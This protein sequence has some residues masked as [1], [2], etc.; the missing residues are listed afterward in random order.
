[1]FEELRDAWR[2]AVSN[3]Y[4]ELHGGAEDG[5]RL[6]AMR[7]DHAAALES[8]RRVEQELE[9]TQ[10]ELKQ[11]R[12]E[13]TAY[14][15]RRDMAQR[16]GDEETAAVA[17]RFVARYERRVR[18]LE[19][20]ASALEAE[21]GLRRS[22]V[23]E[24][25]VALTEVEA[26]ARVSGGATAAGSAGPASPG[27]GGAAPAGAAGPAAA[28]A[29]AEPPGGASRAS[30]RSP[31]EPSAGGAESGGG[32]SDAGARPGRLFEE[33]DEATFKQMELREREREAERR[34]EEL[35]R[36]MQ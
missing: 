16:I 17:V 10:R 9:R 5:G 8:C 36:R 26:S 13:L 34:L 21:A 22:D 12:S 14:N 20:V 7:R 4:E 19:G 31:R 2:E 1:M 33:V 6:A 30:G 27:A 11:E 15:R 24:M 29:R 3:F 18:V 28:G 35:K 23:E 25:R 32:R